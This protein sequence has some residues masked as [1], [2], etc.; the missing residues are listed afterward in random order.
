MKINF[1]SLTTLKG[2][3]TR[4]KKEKEKKRSGGKVYTIVVIVHEITYAN[5]RKR[6]EI[7]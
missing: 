5:S 7:C 1:L 4:G 6:G 2:N 3:V